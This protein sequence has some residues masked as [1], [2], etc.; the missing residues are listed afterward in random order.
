[1]QQY[2]DVYRAIDVM[3]AWAT[4]DPNGT[5]FSQERVLQY[6]TDSPD[7]ETRL[8]FGLMSLAGYLLVRLEES[9]GKTMQWHLQDIAKRLIDK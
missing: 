8:L 6:V 5:D 2:D 3:T 7:G 9:S 4:D 1:M